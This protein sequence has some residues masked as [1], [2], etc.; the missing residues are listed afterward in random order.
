MRAGAAAYQSSR[1]G[2]SDNGCRA[3][4]RVRGGPR[5]AAADYRSQRWRLQPTGSQLAIRR[6]LLSARRSIAARPRRGCLRRANAGDS[7]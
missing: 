5:R 4:A 1:R 2:G 7:W 6:A 3:K